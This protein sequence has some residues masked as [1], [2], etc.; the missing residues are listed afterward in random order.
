MEDQNI[1]IIYYNS[2]TTGI[3]ASSSFI[4]T[5]EYRVPFILFYFIFIIFISCLSI[6]F[7][8]HFITKKLKK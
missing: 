5:G 6:L 1:E 4:Q 2:T 7:L 8:Y 3:D